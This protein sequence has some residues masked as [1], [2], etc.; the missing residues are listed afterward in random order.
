MLRTIAA[1]AAK[2]AAAVVRES[3]D[4]GLYTGTTNAGGDRVLAVDLQADR[5]AREVL[6]T[7]MAAAG[8]PYSTLSEESGLLGHG[9]DFPLFIID[10]LDGS[11]QARRRHPDCVVSI[12][13]ATGPHLADVVAGAIQPIPGGPAYTAALGDGAAFGDTPLPLTPVPGGPA[14][15]LLVEGTD[16]VA[17]VGMARRF[18]AAAP[19][20]QLHVNGSIALQLALLAAGCYDLL[21]A[22]QPGARAHDIAAGWLLVTEAGAAY[23]DLQGLDPAAT[24]LTTGD[25]RHQPVAARRQEPLHWALRVARVTA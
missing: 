23:A 18:A 21:V 16:P 6:A 20:C 19:T 5:T 10:P 12:A 3:A 17:C 14:S 2:A 25:V 1:R 9:A 22:A 8:C 4:P 11:A 15:S 13:V 24:P 7:E